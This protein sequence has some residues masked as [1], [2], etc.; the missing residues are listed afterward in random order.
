M[1][2]LVTRNRSSSD[3]WAKLPLPD[4]T[5]SDCL[6]VLC[7]VLLYHKFHLKICRRG[8]ISGEMSKPWLRDPNSGLLL[9]PSPHLV[10]NHNSLSFHFVSTFPSYKASTWRMLW[11][12]WLQC[13]QALVSNSN[14]HL[15]NL[16]PGKSD[17]YRRIDLTSQRLIVP[18]S[19]TNTR[20]NSWNVVTIFLLFHK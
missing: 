1:I 4:V 18:F 20:G 17:Y 12:W 13:F 7:A 2:S 16:S 3:S 8:P 5:A 15:Q 19:I 6:L 9:F 10:T 11:V 14:T